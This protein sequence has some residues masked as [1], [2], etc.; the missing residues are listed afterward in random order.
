LEM[1]SIPANEPFLIKTAEDVDLVNPNIS[2]V[3]KTIVY[4]AE[5]KAE[6]AGVEYGGNEFLGTYTAIAAADLNYNTTDR[7]FAFLGNSSYTGSKGQALSN[8]WYN[9]TLAGLVINPMEAYLHY[10]PDKGSA[11]AP[12]ITIEDYDF[13]N[14]T[15]AIKTLNVDTMML[16]YGLLLVK[17]GLEH[18]FT[19]YLSVTAIGLIVMAASASLTYH[20]I[21]IMMIPIIIASMYTSKRLSVYAFIFTVGGIT[22][23]TYVGYYFGVC[24]ANMALLTVTSLDHLQKDGVFLL[25][26]VNENPMVTLALYYVMPRSLMAVAFY[27]VSNSVNSI[28]RKSMENAMRMVQA[29]SMDDMTGLYS[30]NKLLETVEHMEPKERPVAVIYWDVNQL[31]YVNDTFGHLYGDQLI[32]KIAGS[33]RAAVTSEETNAYRYGGDEFLMII[34]DGTQEIAEDVIEKWRQVMKPIQKNSEIPVSA[35]VGKYE[36]IMELIEI[37]DQ[38]MYKDKQLRRQ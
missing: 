30:K 17:M 22:I 19:K 9:A 31:K 23:S 4:S 35:S 16:I 32:A 6:A 7:H 2:F 12:I 1:L 26:K 36:N 10:S 18:P 8:T 34:P 28:V 29:A 24:D 5:P 25:N 38:R 13:E 20:M 27:Y 15:T 14:G 37:A 11:A 3:N 33:I 21:I